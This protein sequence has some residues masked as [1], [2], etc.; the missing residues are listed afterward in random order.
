MGLSSSIWSYPHGTGHLQKLTC[1]LAVGSCPSLLLCTDQRQTKEEP[2][3]LSLPAAL[4]LSQPVSHL[5]FLY[6]CIYNAGA[7]ETLHGLIKLKLR[8]NFLV[9][10]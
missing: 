9:I 6:K 3:G 10:H 7:S 2:T 1:D 4:P 8:S 5:A